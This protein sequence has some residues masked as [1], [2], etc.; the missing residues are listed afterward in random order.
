MAERDPPDLTMLASLERQRADAMNRGDLAALEGWLA[1]DAVYIH[2][3][4]VLEGKAAYLDS[5]RQGAVRYRDLTLE[6]L[7]LVRSAPDLAVACGRMQGTIVK[8]PDSIGV[9]SLYTAAWAR[10]GAGGRWRLAAF[11]AT[12]EARP[13]R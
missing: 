11:Q 10:E 9:C 6:L 3:N 12:R 8:G 5:L 7:R 2:S 1:E 4:G 13:A